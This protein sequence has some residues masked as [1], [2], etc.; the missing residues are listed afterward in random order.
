MAMDL[1][2]LYDFD[3]SFIPQSFLA[4][5]G[6][7][8]TDLFSGDADM[9]LLDKLETWSQNIQPI[10]FHRTYNHYP[11]QEKQSPLQSFSLEIEIFS[12]TSPL[13]LLL[14]SP[15]QTPTSLKILCQ[16]APTKKKCQKGTPPSPPRGH[17]IWHS[18][19]QIFWHSI[20]Q[21]FW[22]CI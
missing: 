22:H 9:E 7:S 15:K 18:I 4:A 17:S 5:M 6:D 20:W 11:W 16:M 21:T 14:V 2:L 12:D 3:L 8:Q 10:S 1:G 13:N 19:W